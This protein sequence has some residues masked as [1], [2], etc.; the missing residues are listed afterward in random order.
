MFYFRANNTKSMGWIKDK[1]IN[2]IASKVS[3][4]FQKLIG[5]PTT[6]KDAS[7][8]QNIFSKAIA[9]IQNIAQRVIAPIQ[10]K[11]DTIKDKYNREGEVQDYATKAGQAVTDYQSGTEKTLG[12]YGTAIS[13]ALAKY[14]TGT[15]E[16]L[17]GYKSET[18]NALGNYNIG[19]DVAQSGFKT[20]AQ[21]SI[22][23]T[24]GKQTGLVDS[25][26]QELT[27]L[28][29]KEYGQNYLERPEVQNAIRKQQEQFREGLQQF[30]GNAITGGG[31]IESQLAASKGLGKNQSDFLADLVSEGAT[32][33]SGLQKDYLANKQNLALTKAGMIGQAGGQ[34]LGVLSSL[35][36]SEANQAGTG[37]NVGTNLAGTSLGIGSQALGTG[38][39]VGANAAG[40]G[41]GVSSNA[42][43]AAL[44]AKLGISQNELAS[45]LGIKNDRLAAL[46][47]GMNQITNTIR[48]PVSEEDLSQLM[49][50]A[51]G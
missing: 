34:N 26:T 35:F 42:G 43:N 18:E 5:D 44:A 14:Q 11:V 33:K 21:E 1:L 22:A 41:L 31:T 19:T 40:A 6:T 30:K 2:P 50:L 15:N 13:D 39:G 23:D 12:T 49:M 20:G 32:R 28:F 45:M 47:Q 38:L 17:G 37:L 27:D 51:G 29:Q 48:N 24:L 8:I 4:G 46:S 10:N 3:T 36:G 9:P 25:A 7:P 16:A